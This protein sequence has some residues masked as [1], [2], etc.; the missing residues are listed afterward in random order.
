MTIDD[1]KM[2]FINEISNAI[3]SNYED[4]TSNNII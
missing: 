2:K 4:F 1:E 3:S